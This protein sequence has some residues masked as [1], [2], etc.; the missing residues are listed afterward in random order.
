MT[1][2]RQKAKLLQGL[3]MGEVAHTGPFY[4]TIDITCRCNIHCAS[5]LFHSPQLNIPSDGNKEIKDIPYDLFK[6]LCNE[7]KAMGTRQIILCSD[8]EPFLH[9]VFLT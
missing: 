1:T 7:L 8:G 5:C 2:F 3:L 4:A 6:R 9:P